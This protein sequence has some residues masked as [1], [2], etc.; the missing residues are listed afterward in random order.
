MCVYFVAMLCADRFGLGW[1]YDEFKF[2]CHM[3]MHFH[4]YIPSCFYHLIL[5]LLGTFLIVSL[6]FSISLSCVSCFMA[7]KRKSTLSKNPLHSGA[8][9]PLILHLLLFSSMIREPVRTSWRISLDEAFIRNAKSF[10]RF[11][12]ILTFLLSSTDEVRGHCVTSR[13]LVPPWSY[14]SF[15]PICLGSIL[16]YLISFLA[17]E[18]CA[19]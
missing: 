1:A 17:F 16:L 10:Y 13:S 19:L 15:T 6:S 14:K 2:A 9:S 8:S 4:A 7:P 11:S 12:L 3:F 18:V 5:Q